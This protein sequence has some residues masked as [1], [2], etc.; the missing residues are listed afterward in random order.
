MWAM[1]PTSVAK[2]SGAMIIL[3]SRR[4]SMAIRLTL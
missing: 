2:T 4:K 1:P 3:I